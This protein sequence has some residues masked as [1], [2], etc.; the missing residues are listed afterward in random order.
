MTC[1]GYLCFLVDNWLKCSREPEENP[2][3][4]Q[5][6]DVKFH[7][8]TETVSSFGSSAFNFYAPS[9]PVSARNKSVK[10]QRTN[11]DVVPRSG[12]GGDWIM[13]YVVNESN[14]HP[15]YL[16]TNFCCFDLV[17][18]RQHLTKRS[19]DFGSINNTQKAET[20]ST[21]SK[22]EKFVKKL[23]KLKNNKA[24]LSRRQKLKN[25][26]K[27]KRHINI[28][29]M[30]ALEF[31]HSKIMKSKN[32]PLAMDTVSAL[33]SKQENEIFVFDPCATIG[34]GTQHWGYF[35]QRNKGAEEILVQNQISTFA[36]PPIIDEEKF[37]YNCLLPK[38]TVSYAAICHRN[39]LSRFLLCDKCKKV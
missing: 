21:G 19:I 31:K 33:P 13:R 1:F 27:I 38:N 20:G 6:N 36:L 28:R 8:Q 14:E 24:K 39:T 26:R 34:Y 15:W 5:N 17:P 9:K 37:D 12:E 22:H 23:E 29:I 25:D 35:S 11:L 2:S 30:F 32:I 18:W 4:V 16:G 7:D 3:S 10:F